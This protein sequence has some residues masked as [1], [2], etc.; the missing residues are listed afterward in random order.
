MSI[1]SARSPERT[2]SWKGSS[3]NNNSSNREIKATSVASISFSATED[4][5]SI[6]RER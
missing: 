5:E 1:F 2:R 3:I 4:Q 6:L